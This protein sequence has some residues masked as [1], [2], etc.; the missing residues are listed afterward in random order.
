MK[1]YC[2]A[3]IFPLDF[4]P[5]ALDYKK[6]LNSNSCCQR[7]LLQIWKPED[8]SDILKTEKRTQTPVNKGLFTSADWS[9]PLSFKDRP[10]WQILS[11]KY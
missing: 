2:S 3:I 4:P 1:I 11:L 8:F 7:F 9:L 5:G 6:V 10:A